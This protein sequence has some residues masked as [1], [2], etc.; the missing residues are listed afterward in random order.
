M[1]IKNIYGNVIYTSP[2][3]TMKDTVV[4]AFSKGADLSGA[5]LS[6]AYLSGADLRGADLSDADLRGADL[7]D[8]VLSGAEGN[9]K[10]IATMRVFTGI[11]AYQVWAVL[12]EDGSRWVRMGCLF[13]SLDEWE[14]IGIRKS[15]LSQY[16]DDGSEKCEQRVR[17]FE[18]AKQEAL[19]LKAE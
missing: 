13:K 18:Y 6:G 17:A 7:R 2:T 3:T 5:V 19:L 8:A 16:P 11:Y 4:E 1:D 15:N 10:K 12:F 9:K 14:E